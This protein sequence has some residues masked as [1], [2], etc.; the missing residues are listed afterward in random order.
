MQGFQNFEKSFSLN[1][2]SSC[3]ISHKKILVEKHSNSAPK[4]RIFLSLR[5][6]DRVNEIGRTKAFPGG[7]G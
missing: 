5:I 6:F 3:A 4:I 7:H 1:I 2:S